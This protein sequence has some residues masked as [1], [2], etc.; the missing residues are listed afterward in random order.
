M[1]CAMSVGISSSPVSGS[2]NEPSSERQGLEGETEASEAVM[3]EE[4]V[5]RRRNGGRDFRLLIPAFFQAAAFDDRLA[6]SRS[7]VESSRSSCV[8]HSG[9]AFERRCRKASLDANKEI[10]SKKRR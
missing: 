2:A 8:Q 4:E 5:L 9:G 6:S 1:H 10:S 7:L 3:E